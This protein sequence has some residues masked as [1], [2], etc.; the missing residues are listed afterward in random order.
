MRRSVVVSEMKRPDPIT[1]RRLLVTPLLLLLDSS[2]MRG[3][4]VA[5][6]T[7]RELVA[8]V[9]RDHG[10]VPPVTMGIARVILRPGVSAVATTPDGARMIVVESGVLAVAVT[11]QDNESL[12]SAQLSIS[13]PASKE[14]DE[15]FVP[16]GTA[17]TFGATGVSRVRNPGGRSVVA[18][19]VAVFHEEP[20]PIARAFTTDDGISFQLLTSANAKVAP[21]GGVALILERIGLGAHTDLPLDLSHGLTLAYVEAGAIELRPVAGDVFSAR[22]SAAAPY[23][24]PGSL[25]PI[26]A[27]DERAITAG[28]TIFLPVG[29]ECRATN[30]SARAADVLTLAI[31]EVA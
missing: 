2:T 31:R 8:T 10:L 3:G 4:A 7:R 21:Q 18:L 12:P 30:E 28:G 5:S 29:A 6:T 15:L 22:A 23:S 26:G 14:D 19:D 20:R 17:V 1:R 25:Q 11:A 9:E 13:A 24:M 16:A 27:G